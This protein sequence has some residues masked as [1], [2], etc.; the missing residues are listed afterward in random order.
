MIL[1]LYFV[2][3]VTI[4]GVYKTKIHAEVYLLF[5]TFTQ[6]MVYGYCVFIGHVTLSAAGIYF[7]Q[8]GTETLYNPRKW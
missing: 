7:F 6:K 8:F 5:P 2:A 1:N 4:Y 3:D